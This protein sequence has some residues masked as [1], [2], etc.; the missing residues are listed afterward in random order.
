MRSSEFIDFPLHRRRNTN[1]A[2]VVSVGYD[3][4]NKVDRAFLKIVPHLV[5]SVLEIPTMSSSVRRRK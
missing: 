4:E 5:F 1:K 2:D 3:G